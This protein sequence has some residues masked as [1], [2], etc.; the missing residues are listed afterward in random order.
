MLKE[1]IDKTRELTNNV[2]IAKNEINNAIVRGGGVRSEDLKGIPRNIQDMVNQYSKIAEGKITNVPYFNTSDNVGKIFT[3]PL[4][5]A[6]KPKRLF[7]TINPEDIL[8]VADTMNELLLNKNT[9]FSMRGNY[10]EFEMTMTELNEKQF[11]F[12]IVGNPS[13]AYVKC[14]K[15]LAIG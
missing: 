5:L 1:T 4:N 10:I 15:W 13:Y 11:K 6:F 9:K 14:K 7:L 8:K 12:K 3:V 2:K